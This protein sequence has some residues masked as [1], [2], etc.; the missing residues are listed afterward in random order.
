M[1]NKFKLLA[2]FEVKS[3]H[4]DEE[5][6]DQ[7][8]ITGYAST[9]DKDRMNDVVLADAWKE[10]SALKDFLLNPII[11]AFHDH[12]RPIGKMVDYEVNSKGL[13]ITAR[14]SKAAG[15]IGELIKDGILSA[16][17]IGFRIKD[18]DYDEKTDI[19]VV[20]A[21]ELF[22]VSVVS[23]PANA[24]TVFNV[25][26]QLEDDTE[27][28]IELKRKFSN[29]EET[30]MVDKT[31][32]KQ[33]GSE[34]LNASELRAQILA[35]IKKDLKDE[36]EKK[37]KAEAEK[38]KQRE[39]I[40]ATAKTAAER[41]LEDLK[42][43]YEDKDKQTADI[44][45]EF[46]NALK[47]KEEELTALQKRLASNK[48]QFPDGDAEA[49]PSEI[50]K[51]TAVIVAKGMRRP[52]TE[53][54]YFKDLIEKSGTE[55]WASSADPAWE[56]EFN[57]RVYNAM[58]EELVVERTF[59]SIPMS[60]PTM[61]LPINPEAGLAQWIHTSAFR[62]TDGSSTGTAVDHELEDKTL[63]AYKLAAKEYLG[64]EE[65][66]DTMIALAPIVRDAVAR[67]MARASDL[68]L[69]RGAGSISSGSGFD[70]ITGLE[71]RGGSTTDV[72]VSGGSAWA[73]DS[74]WNEDR[75]VD[76]R[77]NLGIYGLDPSRLV[78][79]V[80]HD[81]YY[82]MMKF[83]NFKTV[84]VLGQRA[85]ILTG[86]VG[87]LFGVPVVVS[88]TFDAA[89]ITAGTVGTSLAILCRPENFVIGTLRGIRTETDRS[90]ED[91][92][93]IL[94][95]TRRFAFEDII[96]GVATVNLEIAS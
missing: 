62:S 45:K 81:A 24:K 72:T 89:A 60:A 63:I 51:D 82:E 47:D 75:V 59:S 40:E 37:A 55:H 42:K 28:L 33:E 44:L 64:D 53:T 20:K 36:E 56:E 3:V 29:N 10:E 66:E 21:V 12:R 46:G 26:K 58:R 22:E 85:T 25:A 78:L 49:G 48:M 31:K 76:M 52:L 5:N 57:T 1:K 71:G 27:E 77:K 79:F 69:L 17:S 74:T 67:R 23:V 80:S 7:L 14:I 6:E 50:E 94:V 34:G 96:T 84:D 11:L 4:Q 43:E 32:E 68:A 35:D 54:K 61:H 13:K 15:E 73:S 18:A 2:P 91:Q 8:M 90:V 92:K 88:Q 83:A 41:L 38:Q 95:A 93:N 30:L 87:S 65:E 70:P 19:F 16:F 86:Q 39:E 9:M